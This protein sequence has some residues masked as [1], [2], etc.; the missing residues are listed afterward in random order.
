[1]RQ[2]GIVGEACPL[3]SP[4]KIHSFP[5][6]KRGEN[7]IM[8]TIPKL[9]PIQPSPQNLGSQDIYYHNIN[10]PKRLP[11]LLFHLLKISSS[12]LGERSKNGMVSV[13]YF[14]SLNKN[15]SNNI[16][17]GERRLLWV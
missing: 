7:N 3:T 10:L 2:E 6:R 11:N 14:T 15:N 5:P 8:L 9:S 12:T 1:M 4:Y 17:R 16:M 13:I